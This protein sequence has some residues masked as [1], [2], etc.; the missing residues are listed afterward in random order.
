M[1][2]QLELQIDK[3]LYGGSGDAEDVKEFAIFISSHWIN[4]VEP[5]GF[6]FIEYGYA[7]LEVSEAGVHCLMF[8]QD[9]DSPN[10]KNQQFLAGNE[11]DA[12]FTRD[13]DSQ[14]SANYRIYF[15]TLWVFIPYQA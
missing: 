9:L 12:I 3:H 10:Y 5:F 4:E 2:T 1:M 7:H 15:G 14:P 6:K 11:L 13:D 8:E